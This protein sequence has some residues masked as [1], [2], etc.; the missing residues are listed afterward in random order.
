MAIDQEPSAESTGEALTGAQTTGVTVFAEGELTRPLTA[1]HATYRI[2]R[3]HPTVALARALVI[4][5]VV[6]SSW[7]FDSD[8]S[9]PDDERVK[10][11]QSVYLPLRRRMLDASM[12]GG[13]DFGWQ[14]FE[15]V[16]AVREGRIVVATL[17]QLLHD[18]TSIR[19]DGRT[20][21]LVAYRQ[22]QAGIVDVPA[23]NLLHV[24][25]RVEGTQWHGQSLLENVRD[26]YN[27]WIES[28]NGAKRYDK[29]IAGSHII[30][31]Y[32][33]NKKNVYQG[34]ET[35]NAEIASAIKELLTSSTIMTLP[36]RES[37]NGERQKDF[38]LRIMSDTTARQMSFT[39]RLE[40]LDKLMVRGLLFPER[41]M[42]EGQ[43]GTKAETA[44]QADLAITNLELQHQLIVDELNEQSVNRLLVCNWGEDARG[45]VRIVPAP[46][47][48]ER[49]LVLREVYKAIL[50]NP[51]GFV[52]AVEDID[53]DA[54]MDQL[55]IPK[56]SAIA[57]G[58][59]DTE[60]D[61]VTPDLPQSVRDRIAA[62]E[63]TAE[64]R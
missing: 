26:R 19:V 13:I 7:S 51:L 62:I 36:V 5:P 9:D 57:G 1:T 21:E 48:D 39:G 59:T 44:E 34:A 10:F 38:D 16:Y 18:I 30:V 45:T 56:S 49:R 28:N 31:E 6:A 4:A 60:D 54:I 11:I 17:K 20:G 64:G 37:V 14:G 61:E 63:D 35:D 52:K 8:D 42:L 2:I 25:F 43:H 55:G 47:D 22:T 27:D 53:R 41:A 23:S 32:L 40:Y 15:Q 50:A 46:I 58:D 33:A 3:K 24:G 29:R 12:S